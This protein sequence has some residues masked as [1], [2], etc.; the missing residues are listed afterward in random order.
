MTDFKYYAGKLLG[1]VKS[2]FANNMFIMLFAVLIFLVPLVAAYYYPDAFASIANPMIDQFEQNIADGTV[3]LT[4]S[5]LFVNNFTVA[6]MI[7]AGAALLGIIGITVLAMNGLFLGFFASQMDLTSYMALTLP[8][9]IFEIPAIIIACAGGLVLLKFVICFVWNIISPDKSD[10]AYNHY[11]GDL[12]LS[13]TDRFMLSLSKHQNKIKESFVLLVI[14][15]VLLL[16]A[17][18]IEANLTIPI[19]TFF[20]RLLGIQI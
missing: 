13:F 20:L 2:S 15:A 6:L 4:V 12:G 10:E 18:F 8:H 1:E 7:Y 14:S 17:A 11:F 16:I 3:T 9:G 5:S 19:A